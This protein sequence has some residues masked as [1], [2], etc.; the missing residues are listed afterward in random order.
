MPR[1]EGPACSWVE[2][3]D[4]AADMEADTEA[5]MRSDEKRWVAPAS[6]GVLIE[7]P[8]ESRGW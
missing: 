2:E 5:V 1:V 6:Y 4:Q 8:L 7:R 3:D